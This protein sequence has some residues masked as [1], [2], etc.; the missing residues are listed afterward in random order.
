MTTWI[1]ERDLYL[2]ELVRREGR[3]GYVREL[4]AGGVREGLGVPG[5][6]LYRCLS[7]MPGPLL[8]KSCLCQQH[9][10]LP[11]HRIQVWHHAFYSR[12]LN[13][14]DVSPSIRGGRGGRSSR[15][16]SPRWA[17]AYS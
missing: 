1:P 6:A 16:H 10:R 15:R 8:C 12:K 14:H 9:T 5:Q 3:G 7:C 11:F 17:C 4:C 13:T 2:A